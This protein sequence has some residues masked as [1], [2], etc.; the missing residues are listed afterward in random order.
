MGLGQKGSLERPAGS[1]IGVRGRGPGKLKSKALV[2][3]GL[4]VQ[5]K[6]PR[7]ARR[8]WGLVGGCETSS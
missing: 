8:D 5:S 4:S 1:D 6:E 2:G 3:H 7:R